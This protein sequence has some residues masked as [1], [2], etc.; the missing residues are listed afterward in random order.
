MRDLVIYG[1]GGLGRETAAIVARL[2]EKHRLWNFL[3][4]LDDAK[5]AK[6]AASGLK[7]LGG[8]D[9]IRSFASPLDVAIAVAAPAGKRKL[10]ET[11]KPLAHVHFP[12]LIDEHTEIAPCARL[13]EGA[14]VSH[15]CSISVDVTL[16]K[17]VFINTGSHIGHDSIVG[18]F[19]SIMS[20]VNV[21]GNVR[22][23]ENTTVGVGA[24][25]LQGKTVGSNSTVGMGSI[26]VTNVPDNCTVFGNPARKL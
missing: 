1:A 20:N 24:S 8:L 10:Y 26:V 15:M 12:N 11:L 21:S 9:F 23:G 4:F 7:V 16:G 13:E 5:N 18:D 6:P 2:N 17:C 22:L 3:G 19:C 25:I 14:I